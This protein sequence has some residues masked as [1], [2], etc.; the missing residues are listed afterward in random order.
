MRRP[1]LPAIAAS[2]DLRCGDR[3]IAPVVLADAEC[4]DA[5]LVGTHSL[6]DYVTKGVG[7]RVQVSAVVDR[8]VAEG[9]K[10]ELEGRQHCEKRALAHGS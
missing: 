10:A 7:V 1:V 4:V 2:T 8:D 3:E 6:T 9:I 5:H